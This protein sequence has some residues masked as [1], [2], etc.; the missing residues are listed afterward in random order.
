MAWLEGVRGYRRQP[1]E[2]TLC[3]DGDDHRRYDAWNGQHQ[4]QLRTHQAETEQKPAEKAR[5]LRPGIPVLFTSGYSDQALNTD[6]KD[7]S[8]RML[9]K[10]YRRQVLAETLRE[11][12]AARQR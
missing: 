10:P 9:E 3:E 7:E 4:A 11:V 5:S 2:I 1:A 6:W 8:V 12:L